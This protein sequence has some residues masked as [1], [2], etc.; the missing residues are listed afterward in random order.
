VVREDGDMVWAVV[1]GGV[2]IGPAGLGAEAVPGWLIVSP[3]AGTEFD[4][5]TPEE[6]GEHSVLGGELLVILTCQLLIEPRLYP[7]L[8]I[9]GNTVL[10]DSPNTTLPD[11]S[12]VTGC[13]WVALII[14]GVVDDKGHPVPHTWVFG[15]LLWWVVEGT[16]GAV[17]NTWVQNRGGGNEVLA[18]VECFPADLP[19]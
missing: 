19:R 2:G 13:Y 18:A 11:D 4:R 15:N 17:K 9:P 7:A 3:E 12:R 5:L 10:V 6:A 8:T 16:L 14:G 1:K